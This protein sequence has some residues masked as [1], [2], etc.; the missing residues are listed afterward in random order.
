MKILTELDGKFSTNLNTFLSKNEPEC[1][2][3]DLKARAIAALGEIVSKKACSPSHTE[4]SLIFDEVFSDMILSIY[5]TG[6]A[7]DKPAQT[8]L[9]RS[10]ELGIAIVYLWDLPHAFW[11]WKAHDSDLNFN[12]MMEH[13]SKESYKSFL[14]SLNPTYASKKTFDYSEAKRQYRIL[15]NTIHG[16]IPTH[17]SKLPDRFSYSAKDV[18][19]NLDLISKVQTNLL[20]LF[21]MRF[22]DCFAEMESKIT[23]IGTLI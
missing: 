2:A 14:A 5:F 6:C 12:E 23:S 8:T 17:E 16:K 20:Y 15:S 9:R 13:L 4:I 7:L 11:G 22:P 1:K 10:L 21:R 18:T 19:T 3:I